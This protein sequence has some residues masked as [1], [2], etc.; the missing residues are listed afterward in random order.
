MSTAADLPVW[1]VEGPVQAEA[2]VLRLRHGILELAG[3]C[4][5]DAWYIEVG[6]DEDPV[7]VVTRLSTNL[8]GAPLL[9]HSTSWRR[10]RGSVV[11]SFIVVIDSNQG[12]QFPGLPIVRAELARSAATEAPRSI[13]TSQVIEH[14]LRHLSWLA[15]DDHTVQAV[16]NDE[17]RGALVEYV[18][19][20]FRHL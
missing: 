7:E 8:M 17:W 1:G 5:P 16:L 20:P 4:G 19:E 18:P 6:Q 2:F 13:M 14:G 12:G 9:V 3:P 10:A 11:L 15:R